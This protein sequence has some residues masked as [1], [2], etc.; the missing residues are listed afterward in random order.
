MDEIG[1]A[2]TQKANK[3]TYSTVV[4]TGQILRI[5]TNLQLM[6]GLNSQIILYIQE[7]P[8]I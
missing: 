4:G 2:F 6:V 7:S 1:A 5:T 8:Q 3:H